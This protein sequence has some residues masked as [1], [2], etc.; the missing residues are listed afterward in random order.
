MVAA[1]GIALGVGGCGGSTPAVGPQGST[2]SPTSTATTTPGD[3]AKDC[4]DKVRGARVRHG[5]RGIIFETRYAS[6][7]GPSAVRGCWQ[8]VQV[9]RSGGKAQG[10]RIELVK[11][12][13]SASDPARPATSVMRVEL[14]PFDGGG[15]QGDVT[16]TGGYRA[17][18]AE[19][20]ARL[21][22]Y[23]TPAADWP[24]PVNSTRWYA[25][26]VYMP[27][28]FPESDLGSHWLDFTQWKGMYSG[29]PAVALGTKD[30]EIVVDGKHIDANLHR[31]VPG[32]WL[33]L[34]IGIHFSPDPHDGW[35]TVAINGRTVLPVTHGATMNTYWNSDRHHE[36]VDPSYF[37]QGIYR[38]DTWDKTAVI[39]FGP[40]RIGTTASSVS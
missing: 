18:R 40:V 23:G 21:G 26:S 39:Y 24:D 12:P 13:G 31:I 28:G 32:R 17:N 5:Y 8:K 35:M 4:I 19:V 36:L 7:L 29:S 20:L 38:S 37:K 25:Y 30:D 3:P 14:R 6:R 16:D 15:A 22:D 10:N 1:I 33:S 11:A 34:R 27:P 2:A 9:P